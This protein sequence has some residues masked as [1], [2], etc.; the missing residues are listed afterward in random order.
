MTEALAE[1]PALLWSDEFDTGSQPRSDT[2]SFDLGGGG[3][4]NGELQVYTDAPSNIM[5]HDGILK[6]VAQKDGT[7]PPTFTSARIKTEGKLSFK[8]GTLSARIQSPDVAAGLWPA[9]WI[10][11]SNVQEVGWPKA[12]T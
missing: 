3:W 11:G 4:G 5:V 9:F 6:I 7:N 10:L 8:Y 12:G 1:T 2:W